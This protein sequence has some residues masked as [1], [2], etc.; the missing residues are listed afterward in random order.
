MRTVVVWLVAALA[1]PGCSGLSSLNPFSSS[2]STPFSGTWTGPVSV[3]F[4]SAATLQLVLTQSG[5]Q[6]TGTWTLT[7]ANAAQNDGGTVSGTINGSSLSA[8]LQP[9]VSTACADTVSAT[10]SG[11][12]MTGTIA[13]NVCSN[14]FG[15]TPL[16]LN[17]Q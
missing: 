3:T 16:T 8:N 11:T 2:S 10:L 4:T 13:S 7:F 1:L 6:V 15:T 12:Q 9:T 5:S 14:G 17:K